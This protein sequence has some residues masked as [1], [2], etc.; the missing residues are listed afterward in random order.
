M[1]GA[2]FSYDGVYLASDTYG[3]IV[4]SRSFQHVADMRVDFQPS[5][6]ASGGQVQ[7]SFHGP[8]FLNLSCIINTVLGSDT[9]RAAALMR[10]ID[11]MAALLDPERGEKVLRI[12]D[13]SGLATD[14][15]RRYTAIIHGP[16]DKNDIGAKAASGFQLNFLV[17]TGKSDS[18]TETTRQEAI[19]SDP[20]TYTEPASGIVVGTTEALPVF[21]L[22]NTD[23]T[24][25]TT[26]TF[27]N[28]TALDQFSTVRATQT[29]TWNGTLAQNDQL[30]IDSDR[31][32][33]EKSTDG[34]S[35]FVNAMG[36]KAAGGNFPTLEPG[37]SNDFRVTGFVA[38]TMDITYRARF[39]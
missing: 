27:Q 32:H 26:L 7:Q 36:A 17:A 19:A 34:G 28:E 39:L 16:L 18:Q 24:S 38:G 20:E 33:I 3:V 1:V 10:Q 8:K 14:L 13:E 9:T 25:I 30:R 35:T 31:R 5:G 15:D 23:S 21:I 2:S 6:G 37:V 11:A 22:E 12:D 4:R 29:I